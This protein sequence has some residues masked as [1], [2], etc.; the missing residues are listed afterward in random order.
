MNTYIEMNDAVMVPRGGS[1]VLVLRG[2]QQSTVITNL[3][4]WLRDRNHADLVIWRFGR[5]QDSELSSPRQC[6]DVK[7]ERKHGEKFTNEESQSYKVDHSNYRHGRHAVRDG[8]VRRR[9][10]LGQRGS[11]DRRQ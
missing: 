1:Y 6:K 9:R 7:F 2:I 3:C 5:C 4:Q 8:I 10:R 11:R